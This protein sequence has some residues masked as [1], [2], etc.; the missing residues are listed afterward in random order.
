MIGLEEFRSRKATDI[1]ST[2]VSMYDS[3]DVVVT[4]LQAWLARRLLEI[5]NYRYEEDVSL[6]VPDYGAGCR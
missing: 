4:E 1:L 3:R 5:K 6:I 2:L